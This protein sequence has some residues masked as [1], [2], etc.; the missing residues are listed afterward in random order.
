[1]RTTLKDVV[2]AWRH[3]D[4]KHIH[5]AREHMSESAYWESGRPAAEFV[6][7]LVGDGATVMDF[8]CGDGRIALPM[9]KL[10]MIV[11]AVDAAPEMIERLEHEAKVQ[12]VNG[13]MIQTY[14]SDGTESTYVPSIIGNVDA[15]NARAVFIHHSHDDVA[16]MVDTLTHWLK[17]GGY[18]IADWPIGDHHERRDWIDVTTWDPGR[19][20]TV[21][22]AAG[23]TLVSEGNENLPSVW[24]KR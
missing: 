22:A 24:V 5:P 7:N 2:S 9:A 12:N 23:L 16:T 17:P 4:P 3:A 13:G 1:M 11:Y 18:L 20:A 6:Y 10:G 14:V 8:G 19:R 15:V 21:A